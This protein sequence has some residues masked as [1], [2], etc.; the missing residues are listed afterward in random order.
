MLA[1]ERRL[2]ALP[3]GTA[4]DSR[5]FMGREFAP[6]QQV[7]ARAELKGPSRMRAGIDLRGD[8]SAEAW[9][10]RL[11]KSVVE[12]QAGEDAYAALRR[13]LHAARG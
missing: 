4:A 9:T 2:G 6:V 12:L 3:G 13:I 7:S 10:G 5:S 1:I 8:G 11:S